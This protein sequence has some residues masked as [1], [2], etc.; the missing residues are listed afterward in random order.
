MEQWKASKWA[1]WL[2]VAVT[3][4]GLG[5]WI[6]G[7]YTIGGL[8]Q[9]IGIGISGGVM[10]VVS[11]IRSETIRWQDSHMRRVDN[12][13]KTITFYNENVRDLVISFM[14]DFEKF[15]NTLS[16]AQKADPQQSQLS[17]NAEVTVAFQLRMATILHRIDQ[18]AWLMRQSGYLQRE[19]VIMTIYSELSRFLLSPV[20]FPMVQSMQRSSSLRNVDYL[21]AK[22]RE[23]QEHEQ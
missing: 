14:R 18:L 12:T 5:T 16:E 4:G 8:A 10:G 11:M 19:E 7:H 22:L 9:L 17:F 13:A 21:I 1:L 3:L 2:I 6:F 20:Y 15:L 23:V